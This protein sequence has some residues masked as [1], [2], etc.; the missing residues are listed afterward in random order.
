MSSWHELPAEAQA[1]ILAYAARGEGKRCAEILNLYHAQL[2]LVHS[3]WGEG[4]DLW[5]VLTHKVFGDDKRPGEDESWY[6]LF[7]RLCLTKSP[8]KVKEAPEAPP[9]NDRKRG[10]RAEYNG[11]GSSKR[12]LG[13]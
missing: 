13:L 11:G 3:S 6:E 8:D 7:R 2:K 5:V 1:L 4:A 9:P 12:Q 10:R